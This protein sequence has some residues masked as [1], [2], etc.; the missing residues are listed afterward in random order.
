MT[1]GTRIDIVAH[2]V[3]VEKLIAAAVR[4]TT[5]GKIWGVR[6][7][8]EISTKNCAVHKSSETFPS[9]QAN[10]KTAHPKSIERAPFIQAF[11]AF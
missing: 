4:K 6:K 3:P 5:A 10:T 8:D 1:I 7:F 11:N 2:E 9:V